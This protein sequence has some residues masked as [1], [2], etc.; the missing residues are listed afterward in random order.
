MDKNRLFEE[1]ESPE[2]NP[3]IHG[4]LIFHKRAKKTQWGKDSLFNKWC[5]ESWNTKCRKIKFAPYL[6]QLTNMNSKCINYLNRR[7]E[8]IKHLEENIEKKSLW[9]GLANIFWIWHQKQK[10]Q[11]QKLSG[12]TSNQIVSDSKRYIQ[13]N[14]IG[15]L[16]I[17]K[18]NCESYIW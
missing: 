12:T 11:K 3:V 9:H 15:T 18:N 17:G 10:Q 8:I 6:T 4:R 13:Q 1:I 16:Q 14:R 2:I 7:P 5:C